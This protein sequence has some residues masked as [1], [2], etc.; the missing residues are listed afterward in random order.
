[1]AVGSEAGF[2]WTFLLFLIFESFCFVEGI[3]SFG[4]RVVEDVVDVVAVAVRELTHFRFI[5]K[6]NIINT[7]CSNSFSKFQ[8]YQ[9]QISYNKQTYSA[10]ISPG[11]NCRDRQFFC[12]N[13]LKTSETVLLS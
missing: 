8:P 4:G 13:V 11:L 9:Q 1:V 10:G 2:K 12:R 6:D 3:G 7:N 5:Y